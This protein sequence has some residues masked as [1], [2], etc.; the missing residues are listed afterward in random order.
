MTSCKDIT[1]RQ[2]SS[3]MSPTIKVGD[4]VYCDKVQP[5]LS[6]ITRGDIVI[7]SSPDERMSASDGPEAR[8]IFRIIGIG[9]DKIQ[10]ID[11]RVFV[12]D[13]ALGGTFASGRYES[14]ETVMDYGPV[15]VPEGEYFL[16]GDNLAASFDSRFWKR[17]TVKAEIIICK[18]TLIKDGKTGEIREL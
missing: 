16:V 18:A 12:N 13:N 7:I 17:T 5:K 3:S 11:G 9:G 14:N 8:Y 2:A 1:F 6:P 4:T 10:V 15:Y